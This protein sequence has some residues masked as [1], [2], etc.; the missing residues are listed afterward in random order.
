MP[1]TLEFITQR[2]NLGVNC[3][4]YTQNL[5]MLCEAEV[6]QVL[7][8]FTPHLLFQSPTLTADWI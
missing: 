1:E 4:A 2:V 3:F 8:P 6:Q 5:R 7:T